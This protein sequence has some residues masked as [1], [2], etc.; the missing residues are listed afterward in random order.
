V[1][2][3][4][5]Q[6][7]KIKTRNLIS[8]AMKEM[9]WGGERWILCFKKPVKSLL[10][11]L[12]LGYPQQCSQRDFLDCF[13]FFFLSLYILF[14]KKSLKDC[15]KS[16]KKLWL[17]MEGHEILKRTGGNK[18]GQSILLFLKGL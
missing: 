12:L 1:P 3:S 14:Q 6:K 18:G 5:A 15:L 16:W 13:F 7:L 4:G 17:E 8:N 11:L 9:T 10:Q 2:Q